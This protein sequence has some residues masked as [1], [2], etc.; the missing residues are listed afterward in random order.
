M[1]LVVFFLQKADDQVLVRG[2]VKVV[3]NLFLDCC[4][5]VIDSLTR[6]RC[7]TNNT[8]MLIHSEEIQPLM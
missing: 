6:C 8:G 7:R 5:L 1:F 4:S 3:F 2:I